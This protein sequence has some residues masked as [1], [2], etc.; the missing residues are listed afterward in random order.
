MA[1]KY[2]NLSD[3]LPLSMY[4]YKCPYSMNAEGITIHNTGNTYGHDT[5]VGEIQYM[6]STQSYTSFHYAVDDTTVACGIPTNRNSF[7]ASDGAEGYG[8]RS[9]ISIEICSDMEYDNDRFYKACLNAAELT[10]RLLSDMYGFCN[11]DKVFEHHDF[12]PDG[13]NCPRRIREEFGFD[14][15]KS[16]VKVKYQEVILMAKDN[17]P[18]KWSKEAVEWCL[19]RGILVGDE[20]GNLRLRDNMTREELAVTLHRLY[21]ALKKQRQH[22]HLL[23]DAFMSNN[24][25]HSVKFI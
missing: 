18:Q 5:A 1:Y 4:V 9:T 21:N 7:H 22:H 25:F 16:L 12:A 23:G 13:K 17:I 14:W 2:V 19:S 6:Q 15:F 24:P 8:N 11:V 20:K 10:A 3:K